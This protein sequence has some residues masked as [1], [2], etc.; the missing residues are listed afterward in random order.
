MTT[1]ESATRRR[2]IW[3]QSWEA[4]SKATSEELFGPAGILLFHTDGEIT[5]NLG[6]DGLLYNRVM[7]FNPHTNQL[8]QIKISKS[9][10]EK[11][12]RNVG[13]ENISFPQERVERLFE[14]KVEFVQNIYNTTRNDPAKQAQLRELLTPLIH[15]AQAKA[16][17]EP[18]RFLRYIDYIVKEHPD[19]F[20]P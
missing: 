17:H 14:D 2:N 13:F 9:A 7:Y 20:R 10:Y 5:M 4:P 3:E 6:Y 19:I 1:K 8:E 15:A 11:R 16:E 12:W 18:R